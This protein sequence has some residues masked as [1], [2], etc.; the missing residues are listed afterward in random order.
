MLD[1]VLRF[2]KG[3]S[4]PAVLDKEVRRAVMP[5][6]PIE[7][8]RRIVDILE[9]HLSRLDAAGEAVRKS[10]RRLANL[11]RASLAHAVA[12]ARRAPGASV[13][14]VDHLAELGSG[15]TPLK[16]NAAYYLD[17]TIPWITSGD[18]S[19]GLIVD[20]SQFITEIALR[21]TAVKLWP[22]G[23]LLIAMY[24]EGK[25]RGTV[26]ELA[27]S[28][29]T[30]QACAA[31]VL[32]PQYQA[33]RPWVRLFFE[34]NY[35]DVRRQA[36]GG[37]QPNLSLGMIKSME[38]P[39]PPLEVAEGLVEADRAAREYE[40]RLAVTLSAASARSALLRRALLAAA[41]TGRLTAR[42]SEDELEAMV[43]WT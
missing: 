25:T 36:A 24:G 18:L 8:Q 34:S 9:D 27:L 23:A 3:V 4:Y 6:P 17:G 13:I 35:S 20:A 21:E 42:T 7:E 14:R 26:A 2:Q 5:V 30:N 16:S 39:V 43:A 15:A 37:V 10:V 41:F 40:R 12:T 1:Q 38:V 28:A 33:L 29:T 11:R 19:Q 32:D 22:A 31:I